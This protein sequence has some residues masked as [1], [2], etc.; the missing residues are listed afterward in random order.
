MKTIIAAV[1]TCMVLFGVSAATTHLFLSEPPADEET[2][3]AENAEGEEIA[4]ESPVRAMPVAFRPESAVSVE[5]VLQMSDSIKKMEQQMA[6]RQQRLAKDEQRVQLLFDDLATEQDELRAFSEGID[7]KV[8]MVKRLNSSLR[9]TLDQ[10]DARKAELQKLEKDTGSDEQSQ[11]EDMDSRVND[12]KSWFAGLE[13]EQAADYLKEFA[14]NGKL[15]FA[16]SLL[17]KMP[18]RQKAKILEAMSDPI[19]VDQLIDALTIRPKKK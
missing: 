17:Q 11:Q 6:T 5:A 10:L 13:A 9:E 16:A 14:N 15:A 1:V 2:E 7:A 3:V 19:L 4:D 8:D 12:V 18:D